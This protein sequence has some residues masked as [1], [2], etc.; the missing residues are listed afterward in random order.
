MLH[1]T[2]NKEH[3]AVKTKSMSWEHLPI[4]SSPSVGMSLLTFSS[5]T[6]AILAKKLDPASKLG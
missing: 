2:L 5:L 4:F 3:N 6:L 1:D